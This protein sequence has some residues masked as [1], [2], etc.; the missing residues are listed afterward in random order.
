MKKKSYRLNKKR[1]RELY[2]EG[3]CVSSLARKF[4]CRTNAIQ[5][6]VFDLVIPRSLKRS[7]AAK[8]RISEVK[9]IRNLAIHK[10]VPTLVLAIKFGVS[11]STILNVI[12]G[13]FYRY[14]P[15]EIRPAMGVF[16][17]IPEGFVSDVKTNLKGRRKCGPNK[18]TV[19]NL[20][21]GG[22]K[23]IA[24]KHGVAICTVSRWIRKGDPRIIKELKMLEVCR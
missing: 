3:W 4:K 9:K 8:L 17:N 13:K 14:V 23:P 22:L 20:F 1:I 11:E 2:L 7:S 18:N 10:N 5:H 21:P 15:G 6:H 16:K 12:K 19:R 24:K